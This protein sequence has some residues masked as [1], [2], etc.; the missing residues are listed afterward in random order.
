MGPSSRGSEVPRRRA[1]GHLDDPGPLFLVDHGAAVI[2]QHAAASGVHH[3]EARVAEVAVVAPASAIRAA[4]GAVGKIAQDRPGVVRIPDT[5]VE[6]VSIQFFGG[7]VAEM[8]VEPVRGVAAD[9]L[10]VPVRL[11]AHLFDPGC[12]DVPVVSDLVVV[13]DHG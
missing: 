9:D 6:I 8:L 1:R 4:M 13:E 11:L 7:E 5:L 2:F 10:V 3:Q 12:R